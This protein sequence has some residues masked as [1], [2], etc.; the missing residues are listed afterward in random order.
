MLIANADPAPGRSLWQD[1]ATAAPAFG[2]LPGDLNSEITIVGGGYT[3]L[4]AALHLGE[5][6]RATVL[7]DAAD[8]GERASGLNGG[9]VIA[10]VKHDPEE[11]LRR[12]GPVLGARTIATV[13][14]AAERVFAL[15]QRHAIACDPVRNGWIQ[16]AATE[17]ELPRLQQRAA[18]WRRRGADVEFLDREPLARLL[19]SG[20]YA[21]GWIDRRGGSVQPLSYVRGLAAAAQRTGSRIFIR[22]PAM[23]L[24]RSGGTWQIDTPHGRIVSGTVILATN[25]YADRLFEPW[26]RSLVSVPSF[27][28]AT[29]PIP[30]ALRASILPHGQ[31]VS[32]TRQLLR[33]FRLDASGRLLMG[34][35]GSFDAVPGP[36]SARL[37]YRA[38]HE[39]YPQLRGVAFEYHWSGLVAISADRMPHLHELA[40][41]LL[42][43]GGYNGRGIAMATTLG[44]LLARLAN[45]EPAGELGFP[46]TTLQPVRLHRFARLGARLTML[47]LGLLDRLS[48]PPQRL[49]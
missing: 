46:V 45:G 6:G 23:K 42:A 24:T 4:S 31:P 29:A 25:A 10:G 8:I 27:Q 28:V 17:R 1:T 2:T 36:Q 12:Y 19:G 20:Y 11:L 43:A 49:S 26:R 35:R 7:I 40:P 47:Y 34:S 5:L 21:G 32:D 41:G 3:G 22:T 9:Q 44:A 30:P 33:Y 48:S 14:G 18:Q 38:V 15:I 39:I 37:Q 13:G 16:P